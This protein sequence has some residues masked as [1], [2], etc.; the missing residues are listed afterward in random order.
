METKNKLNE[1]VQAILDSK[2]YAVIP[3]SVLR[4][5]NLS[6]KALRLLMLMINNAEEIEKGKKFKIQTTYF[7]HLLGWCNHTLSDATKELISLGYITKTKT[8]N[9]SEKSGFTYYYTFSLSSSFVKVTDVN[10]TN[11]ELNNINLNTAKQLKPSN[12]SLSSLPSS[13]KIENKKKPA[14]QLHEKHHSSK[15]VIKEKQIKM[16]DAEILQFQFS[17]ITPEQRKKIN[18]EHEQIRIA[19][20][21]HRKQEEIEQEEKKPAVKQPDQETIKHYQSS[22]EA[23]I[24]N[25]N[26]AGLFLKNEVEKANVS[27]PISE[28]DLETN[29]DVQIET[30]AC[31]PD[32]FPIEEKEE[33]DFQ[34]LIFAPISEDLVPP[35]LE[36]FPYESHM[37]P[38]EEDTSE[39]IF[40]P[41]L[42][43]YAESEPSEP[44][45][46]FELAQST[47]TID[48]V[49]L[50]A[51]AEES[52]P[53][54]LDVTRLNGKANLSL[55]EKQDIF[56]V[57]KQKFS[58]RESEFSS[59][60]VYVQSV[61][62]LA[63]KLHNAEF[64]PG[65][66]VVNNWS[67][68]L[69]AAIQGII[70][71]LNK[72]E[73]KEEEEWLKKKIRNMK[74]EGYEYVE[75]QFIDTTKVT[76]LR[77]GSE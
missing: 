42:S 69:S 73:I 24:E 72:Q 75:G 65:S 26:T 11:T 54:Q 67:A 17:L 21:E 29:S 30:I 70:N 37:A 20:N 16:S 52:F 68:Y 27:N 66:K 3:H 58:E 47:K 10:V 4:D 49:M 22:V 5:E 32:F 44:S 53:I 38:N 41:I 59:D 63:T 28:T 60:K 19:I 43:T 46:E 74:A 8:R 51:K 7:Q 2:N 34:S 18:D 13:L 61:R 35:V 31:W 77:Y 48:T 71:D 1:T 25:N 40:N 15:E 23:Q 57:L 9:K 6:D 50:D 12:S 56:D 64:K 33:V 39:I 55:E 62:A 14:V 45:R 36:D 76:G